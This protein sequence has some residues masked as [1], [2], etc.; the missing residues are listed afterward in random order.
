MDTVPG[1]LEEFRCLVWGS[2]GLLVG[3]FEVDGAGDFGNAEEHQGAAGEDE[4]NFEAAEW[5]AEDDDG[6]DH[7]DDRETQENPLGRAGGIVVAG[8]LSAGLCG[9]GGEAHPGDGGPELDHG[10]EQEGYR[11]DD[12]GGGE[13]EVLEGNEEYADE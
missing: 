2:A 6:Q 13:D 11:E 12:H 4:E 1:L 5:I 9:F 7:A 8:G 3:S 10:R